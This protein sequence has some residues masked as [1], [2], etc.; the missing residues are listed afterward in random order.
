VLGVLMSALTTYLL[1]DRNHAEELGGGSR[2]A[3]DLVRGDRQL[4]L[5]LVLAL[6]AVTVAAT[7]R[8]RRPLVGAGAR[9][10]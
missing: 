5:A 4:P 6:L 8:G 2:A 10:G 3:L 9:R 7:A 1:L